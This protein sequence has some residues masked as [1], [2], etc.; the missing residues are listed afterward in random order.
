MYL[1]H[2]LTGIIL[3]DSGGVL[4]RLGPY[5]TLRMPMGLYVGV[6]GL[7]LNRLKIDDR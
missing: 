6:C 4:Q 3:V 7:P 5:G 1:L 2:N